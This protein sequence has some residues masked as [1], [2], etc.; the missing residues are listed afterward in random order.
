MNWRALVLS[1][2][3][4]FGAAAE[5]AQSYPTRPIRLVVP[6][7]AGG[8]SEAIAR[9]VAVQVD[10]QLG[11]SIVVDSRGGANGIIGT[12]I[13]AH[14]APDGYTMLHVTSSFVINPHVYRKLPYDIFKDFTTVTNLVIGTGYLLLA[15]P[16]VAVQS[17]PELIALAKSG[18]QLTYGSPGVGNSL[19]LATELFNLK[20]GVNMLHVPFKGLSPAINA[21]LGGERLQLAEPVWARRL[22]LA[23]SHTIAPPARRRN[24]TASRFIAIQPCRVNNRPEDNE[25]AII[26]TKMARS[27]KP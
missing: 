17:V 26:V 1:L 12:D 3:G 23:A 13:V 21:A 10:S 20:T 25:L 11:Q 19:H 14:S 2:L 8:T 15:S 22:R 7:P 4:F 9:I 5:A 27:F 6:F 24:G 16:S 18:K